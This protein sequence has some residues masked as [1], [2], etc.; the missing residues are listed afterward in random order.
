[1][2]PADQI[3]VAFENFESLDV[4]EIDLPLQSG[5]YNLLEPI[6]FWLLAI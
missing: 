1:M 2:D 5:H 3:L 4:A 6:W